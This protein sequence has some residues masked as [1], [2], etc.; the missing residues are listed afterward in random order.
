MTCF[1]LCDFDET[2]PCTSDEVCSQSDIGVEC[3][4]QATK[5]EPGYLKAAK[6][7]KSSGDNSYDLTDDNDGSSFTSFQMGVSIALS[8]MGTLIAIGIIYGIIQYRR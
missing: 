4:S 6:F 8:V 2:N 1:S 5:S 3:K 7:G